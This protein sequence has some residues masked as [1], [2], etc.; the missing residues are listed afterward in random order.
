MNQADHIERV[1]FSY[2]QTLKKNQ[3]SFELIAVI[4]CTR[5]NSFEICQHLTKK[6]KN[7]SAYELKGCGYGLGILYGLKKAQGKNLAYLNCARVNSQ[8]LLNCLNDFKKNPKK[9]LHGIRINRD[10]WYRK[11]SS[12]IYNFGCHLLTGVFSS[13]I[14]GTPK[15][16]SRKIYKQL[17]LKFTDSM[18]DLELL[19]KAKKLKI[20]IKEFPVYKNIRHGGR[21]TSSWK[22]IFR[23]IKELINYWIK[24]RLK[25]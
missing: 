16:F 22:T 19:E 21:S 24:T 13:D 7:F 25:F 2:D 15:I 6:I 8:D 17:K 11:L 12:I 3:F 4:N 18:I 10:V 20:P 23:L 5:D 14:N 9:I 1:I